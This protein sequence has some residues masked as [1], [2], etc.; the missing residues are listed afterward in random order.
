VLQVH[1]PSATAPLGRR[2]HTCC[3]P[4]GE[5]GAKT[6]RFCGDPAAFGKSYCQTHDDSAH[7][8]APKAKPAT[9]ATATP[10]G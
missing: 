8:R 4:I 10:P 5:P 6:F 3:W 1:N 2:T 7:G 9:V